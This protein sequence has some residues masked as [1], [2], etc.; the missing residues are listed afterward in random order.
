MVRPVVRPSDQRVQITPYKRDA[1][2]EVVIRPTGNPERDAKQIQDAVNEAARRGGRDVTTIKVEPGTYRGKIE[3]PQGARNIHLVAVEKDGR[4]PVFDMQGVGTSHESRAV[5][6]LRDNQNIV[7][8]GFEIKNFRTENDAAP[9]GI[10]VR[11]ASKDISIRNN[12]IHDLG[13]PVSR[14][15][16]RTG[17][18]PII[19]LGDGTTQETAITNLHITGNKLYNINLSHNEGI[20]VNG[21]VDGFSVTM[22][23]ITNVNN[24]GIDVIGY[25]KTS[26][27]SRLD[28]ARN[29]LIRGNTVR[30]IDTDKNIAYKLG[31]RSAGGIYVDG[32]NH[33]RIEG[34]L[35]E[36]TNRGIE[37]GCEHAGRTAHNVVVRNNWLRANHIAAVTVGAGNEPPG[38]TDRVQ[39][40]NNIFQ[41]N[42]PNGTTGIDVQSNVTNLTDSGNRQVGRD[43]RPSR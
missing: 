22:N 43:W 17:S 41:A 3:I 29:G 9:A 8:D 12:H 6:S 33:I 30:G 34:N 10:M 39:V 14:S 25:E 18:Q 13:G 31:D 42:G 16:S 35:V 26:A 7:I 20:A 19:V 4:K 23:T 24:I 36:D 27:N 37:V 11:G 5:F 21:N 32:G 15:G 1:G 38:N 28:A 2:P 40:I